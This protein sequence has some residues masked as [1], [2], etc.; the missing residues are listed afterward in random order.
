L[1]CFLLVAFLVALTFYFSSTE[2]MPL[3]QFS[4]V[5]YTWVLASG[6]GYFFWNKGVDKYRLVSDYEQC[7]NSSGL[8]VNLVIWN[9]RRCEEIL[10]G[11]KSYFLLLPAIDIKKK[12]I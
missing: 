5:L 11:G 9:K 12:Y 1:D 10:I 6:A 2:K 7:V 3:H 8:I 4:G